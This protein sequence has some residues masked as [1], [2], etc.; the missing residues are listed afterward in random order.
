MAEV[1]KLRTFTRLFHLTVYLACLDPEGSKRCYWVRLDQLD[2]VPAARISGKLTLHIPLDQA[3]PASLLES[4]YS[5]FVRAVTLYTP[6][7]R[8]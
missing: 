5:V 1:Q 3:M 7:R 8:T 6:Q 4:F 2:D